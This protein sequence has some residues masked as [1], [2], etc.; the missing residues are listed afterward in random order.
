MLIISRYAVTACVRSIIIYL[1]IFVVIS[2]E[3]ESI[4][5]KRVYILIILGRIST[6]SNSVKTF[7]Y[8]EIIVSLLEGR[9]LEAR[10][11]SIINRI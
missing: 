5:R 7:Q 4:Y 3:E 10:Y 1:L 6:S 8:K 11:K 2:K 9:H